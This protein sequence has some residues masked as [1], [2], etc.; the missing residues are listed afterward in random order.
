[1]S[2][3]IKE[4]TEPQKVDG[5]CSQSC[6]VKW[7]QIQTELCLNAGLLLNL[8]PEDLGSALAGKP[9]TWT[10]KAE[11]KVGLVAAGKI[12]PTRDLTNQV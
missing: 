10:Q 7:Y 5:T 8:L 6:S 4:K 9:S 11:M 3:F 12:P 2:R 1:M